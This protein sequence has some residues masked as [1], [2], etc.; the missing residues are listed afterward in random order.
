M[1]PENK[2][3]QHAQHIAQD[4]MNSIGPMKA[5]EYAT[6]MLEEVD[7]D[8]EHIDGGFMVHEMWEEVKE[9]INR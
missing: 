3:K 5:D 2:A 4:L 9:E 7:L 1:N 6:R 8:E